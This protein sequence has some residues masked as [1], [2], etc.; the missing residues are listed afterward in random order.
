MPLVLEFAMNLFLWTA[1]LIHSNLTYEQCLEL[2]G[3]YDNYYAIKVEKKRPFD[4]PVDRFL[5][6]N[7]LTS[8]S[9]KPKEYIFCNVIES[10][11]SSKRTYAPSGLQPVKNIPCR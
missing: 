7:H 3:H 1:T 8:P 10:W 5:W 9:Y 11:K 4:I 2:E 6:Q